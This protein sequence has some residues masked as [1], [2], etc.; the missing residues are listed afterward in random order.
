MYWAWTVR[1]FVCCAAKRCWLTASCESL[2][3]HT[4]KHHC[5]SLLLLSLSHFR[6][7]CP[8][9]PLFVRIVIFFSLHVFWRCKDLPLLFI[10]PPPPLPFSTFTTPLMR[11]N[12]FLSRSSPLS[13]TLLQTVSRQHTLHTQMRS[14]FKTMGI[15]CC[16]DCLRSSRKA[17]HKILKHGC[18][19][20]LPFSH[21]R[22]RPVM[23]AWLTLIQP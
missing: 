8:C 2:S 16:K 9:S 13:Y 4:V 18:R 20:L 11:K 6:A 22:G 7:A 12:V 23:L 21:K 19:D 15:I 5:F 10:Y 14:P 17:L 1:V 3:S